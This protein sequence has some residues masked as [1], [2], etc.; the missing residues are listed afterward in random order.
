[1]AKP[2]TQPEIA[3]DLQLF[4]GVGARAPGHFEELLEKNLI[5]LTSI[6]VQNSRDV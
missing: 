3:V 2:A 5:A 4:N 1:M 6:D